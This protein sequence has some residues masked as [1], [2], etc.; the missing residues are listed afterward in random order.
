[1]SRYSLADLFAS[2]LWR[3]VGPLIAL[4][5]ALGVSGILIVMV[6]ADPITAYGAMIVGSVGS[7]DALATTGVR[8]TPLLL[9]GL[10]VALSFR[11]GVW[12]IGAEGQLYAGAI[13]ATI[14]GVMPVSLPMI[15][16]LPL[17]IIVGFIAGAL[18]AAIPG[19]F[20]AY[21][22]VSEVVLTLMFNYVGIQLAS[23]MV[24]TRS[25]PLGERG[26]AYSQ[27]HLIADSTRL[28]ILIPGT[29]L[30]AG[31]I[32]AVLLAIGLYIVVRYTTF[33]FRLRMVGA[34]P[35]AAAYAG[36]NTAR[37]IMWVMLL[38]GGLAGLAGAAEVLGLKYRL[39]ENF[40][41]GY[42]YDAIAVALLAN[43]NPLGVILSSGFFGALR[44]GAN[45]MQQTAGIEVSVILII[46]ALTVLF[47]VAGVLVGWLASRRARMQ[48][49]R[50]EEVV[51]A[52]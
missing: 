26:A 6:G 30:H 42:G 3:T 9:A 45:R 37:Q 10:G 32:L 41:P 39:F 29:S 19:Y 17:A 5:M 1:M 33:G 36:V 18:W 40:S 35:V 52:D 47:V 24:D 25:G 20:R 16:H 14:I 46:Q 11:C 12:N 27:S 44:A 22:G 7:V 23:Y 2:A 38:S 34:N 8:M 48:T 13:G 28:P 43:N 15:V 51:Y 31:L 21:R 49:P 50:Q 4:L